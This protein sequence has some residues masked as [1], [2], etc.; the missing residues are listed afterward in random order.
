MGKKKWSETRPDESFLRILNPDGS[1]N[2]RLPRVSQSELRRWYQVFIET[3]TFE[4]IALRLQ[5]RGVLSVTASSRG[6]EAVGLGAAAALKPG[7][8]CFPSYRQTSALLYWKSPIDRAMAGLMG[9]SPE[10]IR[11]HLP[12]SPEQL[13]AV[14][15]MPYAVFLGANIPLAVGSAMAD[16]LAGRDSIA[17]AFIGEGST[18]EGD[19][20]D[21]LGFAGVFDSPCVI[22]IQNNQWCISMPASRQ[23]AAKT[24]AQKAEAHGIPHQR[25][26]GNDVF[27][28]YKS[29]KQAADRARKGGGATV[30]EAVTYRILDHNTADSSEVYRTEDEANYWKTLDPFERFEQYLLHNDIIDSGSRETL[31]A[32]AE[33]WLRAAIDRGRAVPPTEPQ[34]MFAS[35]LKGEP[36]WSERHQQAELAAE[37]AGRNPFVDYSGEG[38]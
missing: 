4:E 26:D 34:A 10:H 20:H 5:R 30:I 24:F 17:L 18:S 19:F 28:V 32:E 11:E 37:L 3:R 29:V 12:L 36:S 6:E 2:G 27:A 1:V 23:T 38:L 16:R 21:G 15:F 25:I 33:Q 14:T 35:H 7:D 31:A 9:N 13:P 22:I 8:W